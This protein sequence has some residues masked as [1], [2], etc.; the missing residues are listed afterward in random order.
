MA[1]KYE[2]EWYKD[3]FDQYLDK[4]EQLQNI[5]QLEKD[6]YHVPDLDG[7]KNKLYHDEVVINNTFD[8]HASNVT[9]EDAYYNSSHI[10]SA[11]SNDNT[12]FFK[13][14]GRLSAFDLT[15]NLNMCEMT[16]PWDLFIDSDERNAFKLSQFY[17]NWIKIEDILNHWNIFKFHIL[18]FINQKIYSEYEIYIQEQEV[19]IRFRYEDIW[20]KMDYPVYIYKFDTNY[21][22]RILVT[23]HMLNADWNWKMPLSILGDDFNIT[24]HP[25]VI[26]AVNKI[27]DPEIRKDGKTRIEVL[28]DN[29]DFLSVDYENMVLDVS[30]ISQ[31]NTDY[32]KSE[33]NEYLWL[34][35]FVPKFFHEY[36]KFLVTDILYRPYVP[37]LEKLQTMY[38]NLP[39]NLK[40]I[41]EHNQLY[42]DNNPLFGQEYDG[43]YNIIRPVVLSDA[44][45]DHVEPYDFL[46]DEID[47]LR[48]AISI[49][50]DTV[51]NFMD[52]LYNN[53]GKDDENWTYWIELIRDH[54]R[55]CYD[56][57]G[58]FLDHRRCPRYDNVEDAWITFLTDIE[59]IRNNGY[60]EIHVPTTFQPACNTMIQ[61]SLSILSKYNIAD[62][63]RKVITK[64]LWADVDQFFEQVRYQRPIDERN[65][66]IF[67][68]D[69]DDHVWRPKSRTITHHFPDV[70]TVAP[71][72]GEYIEEFKVYKAFFFYSDTINPREISN[73]LKKAHPSWDEDLLQY[74]NQYGKFNDIFIEKF[75]WMALKHIYQGLLFTNSRW[76]IV[77]YIYDNPSYQR[78]NDLFL[79]TMDP[80][81]KYGHATYLKSKDFNFPFDHTIDKLSEAITLKWN[82]FNKVTNY[83]AYLNNQW[84]PQYFDYLLQVLDELDLSDRIVRRAPIW[85]NIYKMATLIRSKLEQG[86]YHTSQPLVQ[87]INELINSMIDDIEIY[88]ISMLNELNNCLS[89]LPHAERFASIIQYISSTNDPF[90]PDESI[91]RYDEVYTN[92]IYHINDPGFGYR[93]GDTVYVQ[94]IGVFIVE[95][96]DEVGGIIHMNPAFTTM[97]YR[98]PQRLEAYHFMQTNDQSNSYGGSIIVTGCDTIVIDEEDDFYK[99]EYSIS[100]PGT[101]YQIGDIVFI[102]AESNKFLFVVIA[103]EDTSVTMIKPLIDYTCADEI[104]GLYQTVTAAANGTDLSIDIR[105]MKHTSI[106]FDDTLIQH[107]DQY[108]DVELMTFRFNN[109]YDLDLQ[110]EIF[111]GGYQITNFYQ[112][113]V[114]QEN[115]LHPSRID[116]IY[117][118]ANQ[119]E[120]LKN[121]YI[122]LPEDQYKLYNIDYVE[123]LNPG[124]GYHINQA[125]YLGTP[126]MTLKL[127]VTELDGTPFKG[128]Q[129][130]DV[131]D[132]QRTFQG[133]D[134][135]NMSGTVVRDSINNIDDE[136]TNT[137]YDIS[138]GKDRNQTFRYPAIVTI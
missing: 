128:I 126:S 34:S 57:Y 10:L 83:Q 30:R 137:R 39:K 29:L 136:Y 114:W 62:V 115:K 127:L 72:E 93:V 68:Y 51:S 44:Y 24:N 106:A 48:L 54:A 22:R 112:R 66:W 40:T 117:I 59:T 69:N 101:G 99:M 85:F 18:V 23:K 70:Y 64:Y 131:Y 56:A 5:D 42:A 15:E 90:V 19:K 38:Q 67:E 111:L 132:G 33:G 100:N 16:L 43:W 4:Y 97:M 120:N 12:H 107:P 133:I 135:E 63:V 49:F 80:F 123:I 20:K 46:R 105:C 25:R 121:S 61:V 50:S 35:I 27:S 119:I 28:G 86:G 76:E 60:E 71:N 82:T 116:V 7:S 17:R 134:P 98:K 9:L 41:T 55:R 125:I 2:P 14:E 130:V 95:A 36:P 129:S 52:Y 81:F 58:S 11:N 89:V 21:S 47:K 45:T 87:Q 104:W 92:L 79:N 3:S 108:D 94:K 118:N 113:H 65:F 31:I 53:M 8:Q 26:T 73:E 88:P 74:T 110:Y 32:I 96:V 13:W 102:E 122:N 1:V 77:E 109:I 138:I 37:H 91:V 124:K 75:Y 78:F 84:I 103:T 6:G